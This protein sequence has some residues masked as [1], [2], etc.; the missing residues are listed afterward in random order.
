MIAVGEMWIGMICNWPL[1]MFSYQCLIDQINCGDHWGGGCAYR[2]K[3][4]AQLA[5]WKSRSL[6][7]AHVDRAFSV[8][9]C[10]VSGALGHPKP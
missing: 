6:I 4:P 1:F 9:S 2:M 3:L 8:I 5:V 10:S 7:Y